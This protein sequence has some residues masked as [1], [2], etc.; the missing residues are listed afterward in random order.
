M[1]AQDPF[2]GVVHEVPHQAMGEPV[3]DGL[4][5]QVGLFPFLFDL[6]RRKPSPPPAPPS[7]IYPGA[8]SPYRPPARYCARPVGWTTPALP[9]TGPAPRRMYLRCAVWP[10]PSGLVP[11]QPGT[12]GPTPD[13]AA[14]Q[15]AAMGFGRRRRRHGRR[16]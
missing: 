8:Y 9:Y 5:N 4:G 10:G 2:T 13:Q 1:L 12:W 6:F 14:A 16:R 15:A 3:Y 7:P 11:T